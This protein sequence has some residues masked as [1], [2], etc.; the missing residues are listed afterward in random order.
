MAVLLLNAS[1]EPLRVITLRRAIGLMVA[2]K[3]ELIAIL[4]R[5]GPW[6]PPDA[7][8]AP[9]SERPTLMRPCLFFR[10]PSAA[11]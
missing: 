6:S 5:P 4:L 10:Q 7:T 9:F 11:T 8:G 2:S 3:A 1:F